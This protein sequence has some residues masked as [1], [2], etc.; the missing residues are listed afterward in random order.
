[1]N[2]QRIFKTPLAA[3]GI[4]LGAS[5]LVSSIIAA[6][7]FYAVRT[8][9]DALSVTGSARQS[10]TS[11]QVKWTASLSR[12]VPVSSLRS[13]YDLLAQD[14]NRVMSFYAAHGIASTSLSISPI[15]MDEMYDYRPGAEN[16]EKEYNLRQTISLSSADVQGVTAVAKDSSQLA[17]DGVIFRTDMLEYSYTKLP[18]LRVSLLADAIRDAKSRAE[19]L[20][21]PSGQSVGALKAAS[22]GVVQ[23]LSKG[24]VDVSDYGAYDTS[25]IEKEVM[26]TVRASFRIR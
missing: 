18:E 9:D 11:D 13:G 20:A 15:S 19:K 14:L 3:L 26:V 16:R 23:V 22:L 7:A 12:Q 8:S 2:E 17:R 21:E 10:V 24:S 25:N 4:L 5:F 6:Y 1:M